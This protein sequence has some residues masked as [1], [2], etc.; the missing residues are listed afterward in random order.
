M[1]KR[2][3][4]LIFCVSI[5]QSCAMF[6]Y[7]SKRW[8]SSVYSNQGQE[9][10]I[11]SKLAKSNYFLE[12]KISNKLP[13]DIYLDL[14]KSFTNIEGE[15]VALTKAE[16]VINLDASGNI[17]NIL[18]PSNGMINLK[19]ANLKQTNGRT[20]DMWFGY[21]WDRKLD[22]SKFLNKIIP[23]TLQFVDVGGNLLFKKSFELKLV[24][25]RTI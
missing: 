4:V 24:S 3:L 19:I 6:D 7:S 12:T 2:L 22:E 13:K 25:V 21:M 20:A 9:V 15:T 5:F 11:D 17:P 8:T 23:I 10:A 14:T 1:F 16:S 18:I